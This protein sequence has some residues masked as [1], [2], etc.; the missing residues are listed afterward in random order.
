MSDFTVDYILFV[1]FM[2]SL[3]LV[4]FGILGVLVA[5]CLWANRAAVK[6]IGCSTGIVCLAW[7]GYML[8]K[9]WQVPFPVPTIVY[10]IGPAL[11]ALCFLIP[12][13]RR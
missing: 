12:V 8:I 1:N 7:S 3:I 5:T 10:A 4:V 11:L 13:L 6:L 9:P 2:D